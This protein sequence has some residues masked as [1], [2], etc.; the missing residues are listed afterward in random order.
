ECS[1]AIPIRSLFIAD[2]YAYT[3]TGSGIVYDSAAENEYQE[4]INKLAAMRKT[5]SKFE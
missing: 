1:F 5:L 4:I 2:K 3:Q